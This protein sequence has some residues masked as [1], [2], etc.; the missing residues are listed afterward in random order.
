MEQKRLE[1]LVGFL[2]WDFV[3][4]NNLILDQK[5]YCDLKKRAKPIEG[6]DDAKQRP[7]GEDVNALDTTLFEYELVNTNSVLL[8]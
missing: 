5:K 7:T 2:E 8:F 1:N 4:C 3:N 6:L